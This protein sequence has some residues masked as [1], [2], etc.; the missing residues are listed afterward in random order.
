MEKRRAKNIDADV[1]L[2]CVLFLAMA[3]V[4]YFCRIL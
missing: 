3:F 4:R 2:L 1:K